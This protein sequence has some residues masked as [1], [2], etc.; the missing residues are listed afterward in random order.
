M[1]HI[2][3]LELILGRKR[4]RIDLL[5]KSYEEIINQV[6]CKRGRYKII[7]A[8]KIKFLRKVIR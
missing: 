7:T 1:R 3:L 5:Y 4:R 6:K 2:L 8:V